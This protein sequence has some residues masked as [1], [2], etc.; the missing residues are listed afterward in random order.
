[1]PTVSGEYS[2]TEVA[3][4]LNIS[5]AWINKVQNKTGVCKKENTQGKRAEFDKGD[6]WML[7]NVKL[8]RLLDYSLE[9]IKSIYDMERKILWLTKNVKSSDK[10]E[11]YSGVVLKVALFGKS[12]LPISKIKELSKEEKGKLKKIVEEYF[13]IA[14]EVRRR[15]GSL[16]KKLYELNK[17]LESYV[18]THPKLFS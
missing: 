13:T 12:M 18:I 8:L 5:S 1:M 9:D 4:K 3:I 2:L 15:I 6:I 17:G 10:G 14:S 11:A 7:E 16:D